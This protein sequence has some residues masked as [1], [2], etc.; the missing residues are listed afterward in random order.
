MTRTR[1]LLARYLL[2]FH[3][4]QRGTIRRPTMEFVSQP[5]WQAAPQTM[6]VIPLAP[7]RRPTRP[8]LHLRT[9]ALT[10]PDVAR[11]SFRLEAPSD[12]RD[13][14]PY[15][16]VGFVAGSMLLGFMFWSM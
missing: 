6:A 16:L 13:L 9:G 1:L 14:W 15:S 7:A 8:E 3:S 2:G 10:Y 5:G 11:R 4:M 12:W